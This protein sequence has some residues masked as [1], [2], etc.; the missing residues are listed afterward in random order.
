MDRKDVLVESPVTKY[1]FD[2]ASASKTPLSGT[3]ELSPVCNF[4]CRMCYVRKTQA[5]VNAQGGALALCEWIALAEEIRKAGCLYLLLTGGEPLLWPHFWELYEKLSQMGFL[6][7]INTNGSLIDAEAVR[8]FKAN[9]PVRVNIT[10]YGASDETYYELCRVR[11]AYSR[12]T[13]AIRLLKEEKINV[14]LNCSLTPANEGDL[15][16]MINFAKKNELIINVTSYMYPP[17][18]RDASMVGE[19]ERFTPERAAYNLLKIYRL[20]YGEEAYRDYLKRYR[21]G[22]AEPLGLDGD[23]VDTADGKIGCR[24]GNAA[25]W[26]T[27]DG[28]ITPCGM[29]TEPTVNIRRLSFAD[30][31]NEIVSFCS[32]VRLSGTCKN[33]PSHSACRACAAMAYA[34]TGSFAG[35]PTYLCEMVR[36]MN[37]LANSENLE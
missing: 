29:M 25:F 15:E 2:K 30:C 7:S 13:N 27:W 6:I 12:V 28:N 23:C 16:A 3:F 37:R 19:N 21:E 14:K 8:R 31:W 24:A 33:C 1:L 34:E 17:I 4:S 20:Q 11:G 5:E 18:R 35:V 9:P 36:E 10:L 22:T 26:V 32:R